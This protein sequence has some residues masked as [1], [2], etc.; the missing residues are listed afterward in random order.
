MRNTDGAGPTPHEDEARQIAVHADSGRREP[1]GLAA[2]ILV[3][4]ALCWSLFQLWYASPL[5]FL[6]DFGV[7]NN[8]EARSIHLAFALFLTFT[9]FPALKRSPRDRVPIQDWV[10]ALLGA[11]AAAYLFLFYRELSERPGAPILQDVIVACVGIILLL[12]ASRRALGP[13][14]AIVAILLLA[15]TYFGPYMP[16]VI[17]HKGASLY[18][19]VNH[20]WISTE[21]VF[22]VALG[23][24]TDFVFL[25]VLF[26]ALLEKAGAGNFFI[27]VAFSLLGHMR[28]GPAKAAVL[29]SGMTGIISGSSI[30]NVVTTGTFT[31]PLM[32]RLGFPASKAGAIEVAA[33]TNGQLMPPIMGAAA[34]L[35]VEY[36]GISYIEVIKHAFLPAVI[37]YVALIYIVHL[38]ALKANM[39]G[40][41]RRTQN[42]FVQRVL[43]FVLVVLGIIILSG[44]VYYG[45]GWLKDVFGAAASWI[46]AAVLFAT[47]TGLLWHASKVPDLEPDDPDAAHIE[48]PRL[49]PT[50]QSGLHFLLPVVVLVWCLTVERFSPG[51]SAFW[52]TVLMMFIVVTQRPI[53]AWFRG[54]HDARAATRIGLHDLFDGLVTGARNMIPIGVAT[55]AAGIVV[56]TVTQTGIGLVMTEFVEIISGGHLILVLLFTA[57]ICVILG[58]GLPTTAN[59]IVVSA[60]MAPVIVTLAANSGLAV[61]LIAVHLFVFYFGILADDTP[62]V[63]L[64]AY[65][66]AAISRGDPISTGV[67]GFMYDIRTAVL[68]FMFI[69]NTELL[70]IGIDSVWHLLLTVVSAVGAMLVFAAATQGYFFAKSRLWESALLLLA[71]FTLF[72]PGFWLDNIFPPT[73]RI[74]PVRILEVAAEKPEDARLRIVVEGE[75][76]SGEQ[77]AKTLELPLGA[78]GTGAARMQGAGLELRIEDGQVWIDNV[79]WGSFAAKQGLEFDWQVSS[80]ELPLEQ[81]SKYWMALPALLA[82]A[83][84]V[85]LQRRRRALGVFAGKPAG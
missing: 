49:G 77:V 55:A 84:V 22:G 30:A 60:L 28:G 65:A 85:V 18:A 63:G 71:A 17:A 41:P 59:Y 57:M 14:L 50:V 9:S 76:V 58:L 38:E 36:V 37:S 62:P 70:M 10:L 12:E 53:L 5:P 52:A 4:T 73:E 23:V 48:L 79:V 34:F 8:A 35:M 68:P 51:L 61:P 74:E 2:R 25:F 40:L 66:A 75:A 69:F 44:V 15:Y 16:S 13:P 6:F 56:G 3:G 39:Q 24:S 19:I 78:P 20:Q 33:S 64:A 47:Y 27:K 72:R 1:S 26:G 42:T 54:Q 80:V 46:L 32:K 21:G 82:I 43:I 31:I 83:L 81:P 67:Q 7:F 45:V 11:F 29:A